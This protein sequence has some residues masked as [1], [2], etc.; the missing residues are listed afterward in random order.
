MIWLAEQGHEII[1][2]ELSTIAIKAFFHEN[3]LKPAKQRKGK[4]TQWSHGRIKILCGDFFALNSDDLGEIDT[5][6][7][8]AALTA[9]PKDTRKLYVE[10]MQNIIS[11]SSNVFLLTIEDFEADNTQQNYGQ[12]DAEITSLYAEHFL[13]KLT[14]TE[15]VHDLS[16]QLPSQTAGSAEFK[17]YKLSGRGRV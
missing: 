11:D 14:Y 12:V 7:D 4:F 1:A 9:L 2:I 13:I 3:R 15:A 10:H 6:Y 8:R 17:V 16:P 5:V